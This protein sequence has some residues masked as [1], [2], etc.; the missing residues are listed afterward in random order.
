MTCAASVFIP[1]TPRADDRRF[2]VGVVGVDVTRAGCES[3][4][5]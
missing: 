1:T 4:Q 5:R 2:V 3:V